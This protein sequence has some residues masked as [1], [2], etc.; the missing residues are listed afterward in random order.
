MQR[1]ILF[2]GAPRSALAALTAMPRHLRSVSAGCQDIRTS[3]DLI[4]ALFP[5]SSLN[6]QLQQK[7]SSEAFFAFVVQSPGTFDSTSSRYGPS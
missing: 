5:K 3:S 4:F 1:G 7:Q 2:A 6:L